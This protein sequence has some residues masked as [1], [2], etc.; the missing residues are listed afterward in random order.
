M[1]SDKNVLFVIAQKDFR[2]EE[3]EDSRKVIEEAGIGIKVASS[4]AGECYGI[5]GLVIQ[6]DIDFSQAETNDF[7]G[8]VF[9]GGPGVQQYFA[10]ETVLGLAKQF[11]LEGK[12]ICAIC[13]A[14]VILAN[15][16]LLKGKKVTAWSGAKDDLM[17]AGAIF[18]PQ[19]VMVDGNIVTADG[20]GSAAEFGQKIA[21]ILIG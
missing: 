6:A 19:M 1:Q 21:D 20:P 12:L 7:D 2:D 4:T 9:V 3:Y 10:D 11:A 14:P 17:K 13:W 8:V 18:S 16:G 5:N 15:A